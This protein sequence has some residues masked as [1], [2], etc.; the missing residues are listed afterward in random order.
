MYKRGDITV[1]VNV[2]DEEKSYEM[3]GKY[4]ELLLGKAEKDMV[5]LSP[6][7]AKMLK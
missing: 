6:M 3:K 2:S 1:L 7:S 5:V 4:T